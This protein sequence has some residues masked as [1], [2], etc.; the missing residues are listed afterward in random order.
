MMKRKP[1]LTRALQIMVFNTVIALGIAIFMGGGWWQN[2]VYSQCIGLSIWAL[3]DFGQYWLLPD[4]AK[5]WRRMFA[6]APLGAAL[7]YVLG[8][9]AAQQ[10]FPEHNFVHWREQPHLG[11]GFLLISLAAGVISTY[12]FMSRE[13]LAATRAEMAR[14]Q[15]EAEAAQRQAA[16]AQLALLQSQL[17][18]HMLFNTLANLRALIALD[19]PRA[20]TM[21][22]HLV[23]YLRATLNASRTP[24]HPLQT[25]FERLRDYL[26]LIKVR[27]G[28]RLHYELDLPAELGSIPVPSLLLQTLVENAIKHGLEPKPEGG[29]VQVRA[30]RR[31][32]Q[33]CLEV[34]DTGL[35]LPADGRT[36]RDDGFGLTL[37]RERLQTHYGPHAALELMAGSAGGTRAVATFDLKPQAIQQVSPTHAKP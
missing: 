2:W 24:L 13:Q 22:D 21:L 7:G 25:E 11:L 28:A 1:S 18:P 6:I 9:A 4:P 35:G 12:Y 20:Q 5:Q 30:R 23:D 17:A 3:V 8:S 26:E 16:Q 33:L 31:G 14:T 36:V 29:Q 19:A 27:M 32:Q 34:C 37:A 10:F 15:R